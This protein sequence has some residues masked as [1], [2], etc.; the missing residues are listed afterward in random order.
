VLFFIGQF[1]FFILGS[2]MPRRA[3]RRE[4]QRL[5]E[6]LNLNEK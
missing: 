4:R 5:A 1:S 6:K 2:A 3:V